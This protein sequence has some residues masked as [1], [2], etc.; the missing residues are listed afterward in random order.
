MCVNAVKLMIRKF[1]STSFLDAAPGRGR[2]ATAPKIVEA[3]AFA[4]T[5]ATAHS[6]NVTVTG[7]SIARAL[8]TL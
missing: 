3:V 8:N 4:M 5:E 6:S 7:R 2:R 1:E